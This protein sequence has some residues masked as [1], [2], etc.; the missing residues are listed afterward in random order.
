[1]VQFSFGTILCEAGYVTPFNHLTSY[2]SMMILRSPVVAVVWQGLQTCSC[3]LSVRTPTAVWT[4]LVCDL[5]G[6]FSDITFALA[7]VEQGKR[8]KHAHICRL[9]SSHL[10]YPSFAPLCLWLRSSSLKISSV[11][12]LML[13]CPRGRHILRPLAV[14]LSRFGRLWL[15][16]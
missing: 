11:I 9:T 16:S 13:R 10:D 1:M 2:L 14:Y 7:F 4:W 5:G 12:C 15:R 6:G 8:E 3:T